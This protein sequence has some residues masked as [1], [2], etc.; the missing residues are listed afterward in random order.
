MIRMVTI[1]FTLLVTQTI[2]ATEEGPIIGPFGAMEGSPCLGP[3]GEVVVGTQSAPAGPFSGQFHLLRIRSQGT[4]LTA[5]AE[6][7]FA[8]SEARVD[9]IPSLAIRDSDARSLI[10]FA[11][12]AAKVYAIKPLLGQVLPGWPAPFPGCEHPNVVVRKD[13]SIVVG[14]NFGKLYCFWGPN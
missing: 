12:E 14:G 8:T 5:I 9:P 13:G 11:T 6:V 3:S 7:L 4:G 1:G 10:L 2:N